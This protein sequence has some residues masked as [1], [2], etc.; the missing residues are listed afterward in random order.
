MKLAD[1][2]LPHIAELKQTNLV[3]LRREGEV[4]LAMKKRFGS[5]RWNGAGG[6]VEAG[7][8]E[9]AAARREVSEEIGVTVGVLREVAQLVFYF[10][11]NLED[12]LQNIHCR[13]YMCDEW[14]GEPAESEEMAP[15][16]FDETAI[17][18]D[19]MWPDDRYW[20]PEVLAGKYVEATFL[21]GEGDVVLDQVI[22]NK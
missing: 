15:Q 18:Y 7:E 4:L 8:S 9:E 5:G 6:K 1:L 13:V 19:E 20:L 17:P 14:E 21:F 22:L 10:A 3:F 11:D 2:T 16:W 12:P